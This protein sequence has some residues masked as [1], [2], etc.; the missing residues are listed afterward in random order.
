MKVSMIILVEN[1]D[2]TEHML[3]HVSFFLRHNADQIK[4]DLV[5]DLSQQFRKKYHEIVKK[6]TN[7]GERNPDTTKDFIINAYKDIIKQEPYIGSIVHGTGPLGADLWEQLEDLGERYGALD[8]DN[9][10]GLREWKHHVVEELDKFIWDRLEKMAEVYSRTIL[11]KK[12]PHWH[13]LL[14][15]YGIF[16]N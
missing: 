11:E 13:M 14:E 6:D 9:N 10:I 3:D 5:A 1:K 8:I 4:K 2:A 12:Y 15:K 16:N 7:Y